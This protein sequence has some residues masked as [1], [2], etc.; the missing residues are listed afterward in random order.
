[1]SCNNGVWASGPAG[2]QGAERLAFLLRAGTLFEAEWVGLVGAEDFD[3]GGEEFQLLEGVAQTGQV[4]V[5][6]STS[7]RNCVAVKLP[8]TM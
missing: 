5:A 2:V 6:S 8:L 3:F 1:M 7:E 4:W